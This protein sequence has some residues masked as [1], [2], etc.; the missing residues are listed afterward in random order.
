MQNFG[1]G[2]REMRIR[3]RKANFAGKILEGWTWRTT[4][5]VKVIRQYREDRNKAGGILSPT[6]V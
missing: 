4:G 1:T 5:K 2:K 3:G 6:V